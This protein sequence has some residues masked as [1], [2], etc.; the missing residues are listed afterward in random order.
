ME[1]ETRT[2][3]WSE[4]LEPYCFTQR[5]SS[6]VIPPKTTRQMTLHW[7]GFQSAKPRVKPEKTPD[8]KLPSD[9]ALDKCMLFL[10]SS[11]TLWAQE[12]TQYTRMHTYLCRSYIVSSSLTTLSSRNE[13]SVCDE[14]Q[15]PTI[16][17]LEEQQ[18]RT[19]FQKKS[20]FWRN[21]PSNLR[22][23]ASFKSWQGS[24]LSL[25]QQRASILWKKRSPTSYMLHATLQHA[26]KRV[27][28][29]QFLWWL[30]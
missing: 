5:I 10:F 14:S 23:K 30:M 9:P 2:S 18:Y 11:R 25:L 16:R 21:V 17:D 29:S 13:I 24:H 27:R 3:V 12:Y 8:T 15:H 1:F 26:S 19:A 22:S 4:S 7:L 28:R 20:P 6:G